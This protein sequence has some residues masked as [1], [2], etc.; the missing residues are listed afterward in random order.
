M[1]DFEGED[2][3]SDEELALIDAHRAT[4][5]QHQMQQHL[6]N[7]ASM[8]NTHMPHGMYNLISMYMYNTHNYATW[9]VIQNL[10]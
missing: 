3:I 10:L 9:Y 5:N 2:F 6:A 8:Y 4:L 1:A 7:L